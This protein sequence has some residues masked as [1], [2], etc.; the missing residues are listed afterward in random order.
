[1]VGC[2]GSGYCAAAARGSRGR[3]TGPQGAPKPIQGPPPA[4]GD[5]RNPGPALGKGAVAPKAGDA[6]T[7]GASNGRKPHCPSSPRGP[8]EDK[9]QVVKVQQ[10]GLTLPTRV[11][12][13]LYER[14]DQRREAVPL[15]AGEGGMVVKKLTAGAYGVCKIIE[16]RKP[17]GRGPASVE[18][19]WETVAAPPSRPEPPEDNGGHRRG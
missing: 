9:I 13:R 18:A 2:A 7:Q 12:E 3:R 5:Q 15:V 19:R 1:M 17:R 16:F 11:K 14:D 4:K 10:G 8:D 6:A